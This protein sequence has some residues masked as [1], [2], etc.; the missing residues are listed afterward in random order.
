VS[1]VSTFKPAQFSDTFYTIVD[2]KLCKFRR[3]FSISSQKPKRSQ[4]KDVFTVVTYYYFHQSITVSVVVI[5]CFL[6]LKN[7]EQHRNTSSEDGNINQ[8]RAQPARSEAGSKSHHLLN[9]RTRNIQNNESP[10]ERRKGSKSFAQVAS[11]VSRMRQAQRKEMVPFVR[12]DGVVEDTEATNSHAH[13]EV[14]VIVHRSTSS[15]SS[16]TV[17]SLRSVEQRMASPSKH[18]QSRDHSHP[19]RRRHQT[20]ER[21]ENN[22]RNDEQS[23][24]SCTVEKL[25]D[26]GESM[27]LPVQVVDIVE[28]AT[29]S[30]D[31]EHLCEKSQKTTKEG[32]SLAALFDS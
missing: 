12:Y 3:S 23:R 11:G 28:D 16:S 6:F 13:R 10:E 5:S 17:S 31:S 21:S 15:S 20:S 29:H 27:Q 19:P 30:V 7:L 4:G 9:E 8:P 1:A 26:R 25:S 22:I 18:V 14:K 32:G 24:S 2:P